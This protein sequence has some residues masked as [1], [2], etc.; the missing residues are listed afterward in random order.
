MKSIFN[1]FFVIFFI[2]QSFTLFAQTNTENKVLKE[3]AKNG[4]SHALYL[5]GTI[6]RDGLYEKKNPEKAFKHFNLSS[7]NGYDS[8]QYALAQCYELGQGTTQDTKLA[9]TLYKLA[10]KTHALAAYKVGHF[11]LNGI[12]ET[13]NDNESKRYYEL[14]CQL[15]YNTA[16]SIIGDNNVTS[17]KKC[18]HEGNVD[19]K[20]KLAK[21]L[22]EQKNP[23][24]DRAIDWYEMAS[25]DNHPMAAFELA[26][27]YIENITPSVKRNNLKATELYVKAFNLGVTE[28][29][30]KIAIH[31]LD[32]TLISDDNPDKKLYI[33]HNGDAQQRYD[34]AIEYRKGKK[35]NAK[36]CD[37]VVHFLQESAIN[38]N[39]DAMM[40]LA[41]MYDKGECIEKSHENAFTWYKKASYLGNDSALYILGNMY[42]GGSGT[43]KD[44][45]TAIKMYLRAANRGNVSADKKLKEFDIL[46][47]VDKNDYEYVYF[48][49]REGELIAQQKLARYFLMTKN[50]SK[51]LEWLRKAAKQDPNI[52]LELG[53]IYEKGS[54]DIPADNFVAQGYYQRAVGK[55][56]TEGHLSLSNLYATNDTTQ[57]E[58]TKELEEYRDKTGRDKLEKDPEAY[59]KSAA[60][61]MKTKNFG[62]AI[63]N[64][65]HYIRKYPDPEEAPLPIVNAFI[66]RGE[67]HFELKRY[68]MAI[69]D[70]KNAN[71]LIEENSMH[72]TLKP[73]VNK[74]SGTC[75]LY[76]AKI[77]KAMNEKYQSALYYKKAEEKGAKLSK[78]EKEYLNN[79]N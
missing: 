50:P 52:Y 7:L 40:E 31:K 51:G 27:Y 44:E 53:E 26:N 67:A 46:R 58:A 24:H 48:K 2:A 66:S 64:Y 72:T 18:A 17:I 11:Y 61:Y 63:D 12:G 37:T 16:C 60:L 14:S 1:L 59:I 77:A 3:K 36:E 79:I 43:I 15:G 45:S 65:S 56:V 68:H 10:S 41:S 54:Y 30:E 55:G 74:L 28:A 32:V 29:K 76:R 69:N 38:N 49:A 5:L 62:K 33:A 35:L 78:E 4:D 23:N 20:Y 75:L 19:C 57:K 71:F 22:A 42:L 9:L 73:K 39:Q 47:F 8:A 34:F 25:E 70:F 13:R 6:Y 21:T